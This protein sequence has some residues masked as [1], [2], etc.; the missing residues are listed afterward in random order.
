MM[1]ERNPSI[2]SVDIYVLITGAPEIE[3]WIGMGNFSAL[4]RSAQAEKAMVQDPEVMEEP[5]KSTEYLESLGRRVIR[6]L[7][8]ER[9]RGG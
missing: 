1:M 8:L 7:Q 6:P 9:E 2:E 4:D 5:R 3:A